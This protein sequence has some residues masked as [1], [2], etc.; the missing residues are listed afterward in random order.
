LRDKDGADTQA[1]LVMGEAV[2]IHIDP[3]MIE[4]GIYQTARAQPITRGGGPADYFAVT[5]DAL[6]LMGRPG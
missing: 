2:G 4:N 5:E 3:A 6:F 1:W